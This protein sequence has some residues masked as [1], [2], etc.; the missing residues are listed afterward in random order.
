MKDKQY[1]VY[2]WR[3]EHERFCKIGRSIFDKFYDSVLK[4]AMRFSILNIEI[5]LPSVF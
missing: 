1:I 2:C 5:V 4:P 3:F